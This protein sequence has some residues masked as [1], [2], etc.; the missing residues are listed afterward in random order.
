MKKAYVALMQAA[1]KQGANKEIVNYLEKA[2]GC[3]RE[4]VKRVWAQRQAVREGI[5]NGTAT[6]ADYRAITIVTYRDYLELLLI[7]T[8]QRHYPRVNRTIG[9]L[10]KDGCDFLPSSVAVK[11]QQL[12]AYVRKKLKLPQEKLRITKNANAGF[13]RNQDVP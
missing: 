3:M 9:Q 7:W 5:L 1:R 4:V 12:H 13:A 10:F 2:E 6:P 11:Y 8:K